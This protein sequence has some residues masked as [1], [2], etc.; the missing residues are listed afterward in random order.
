MTK[1]VEP[2]EAEATGTAII[3]GQIPNV[4]ITY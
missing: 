3:R 2:K 1:H 4:S